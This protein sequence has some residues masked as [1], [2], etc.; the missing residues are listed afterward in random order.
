MRIPRYLRLSLQIIIIL[1]LAI[2]STRI[3][4]LFKDMSHGR[5]MSP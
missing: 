1:N 3:L 2:Y 5:D 4:R